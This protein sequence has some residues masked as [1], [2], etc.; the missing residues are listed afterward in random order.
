[1]LWSYL[2]VSVYFFSSFPIP[3]CVNVALVHNGFCNNE[4]NIAEC[5]Y[6]G[7]DCCGPAVS[8]KQ[9]CLFH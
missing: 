6:D 2:S 3:G 8:C 9:L 7:G 1:M 5:V 4:T